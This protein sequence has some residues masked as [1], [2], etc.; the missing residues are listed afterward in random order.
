M[1]HN[2]IPGSQDHLQADSFAPSNTFDSVGPSRLT[3]FCPIQRGSSGHAG[4]VQ[5]AEGTSKG[6]EKLGE[7]KPQLK[8]N[9]LFVLVLLDNLLP[10]FSPDDRPERRGT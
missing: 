8:Q 6:Y 5:G 2:Q 10:F 1:K 4:N 9:S 3:I 7:P